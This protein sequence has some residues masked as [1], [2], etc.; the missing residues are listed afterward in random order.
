MQS[1]I[2][3]LIEVASGRRRGSL[4]LKNASIVNVFAGEILFDDIALLGDRIAGIGEYE[5]VEELDLK[6]AYVV[7][8]L[9]DGHMHLESAMTLPTEFAGAVLPRGTTAIIADPH[10]IANVCGVAG[11]RFML[12]NTAGT[13]PDV[14]FMLPSCIP[15][16]PFD[17]PGARLDAADL[18]GLK[19]AYRVL[20]LGELMDFKGAVQARKDIL[21]KLELFRDRIVDGHAPR[22]AGRE[23]NAYAAAGVATDHECDTVEEMLEKLR[24]GFYILI[25]EGS[26]ARNL[27]ELVKGVNPRNLRRCVFCTDDRHLRDI[28]RDGHIDNNIRLAVKHGLDPISAIT[29]ATLNAAECYGLKGRGAI[30]PGFIADMVVVDD[31]HT[32]EIISVFKNGRPISEIPDNSRN[33]R[34]VPEAV[35]NT[36]HTGALTRE[37]LEIKIYSDKANVIRVK[38]GSLLTEKVVKKVGTVD[39][40]FE[41]L[42]PGDPLKLAVVE[43]HKAS[44]R[45]GLALLDGFG[46]TGGAIASTIS[47]DSHNLIVAGD[48]DDDMLLA[49]EELSAKG[50]GITVTS[51]GRVLKT[52]PLPVAGLMSLK[53]YREID[54]ELGELLAIAHR[55]GVPDDI[56]PFMALSFLSLTVIPEIR[57]TDRGLFDVMEN[58][59]IDITL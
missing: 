55:L 54:G 9:I 15:A 50:G 39:G 27:A 48:N 58:R 53:P 26:A 31:L 7:P 4:V 34:T 21:A 59:L 25:R 51:G 2:K 10:E 43:R 13:G 12:E 19:D 44:G 28:V 46:L 52:L 16:T 40:R 23:L 57:I 38:P 20:G 33:W 49:M 36:M 47:H 14:F 6:G 8:G 1:G 56:E 42:H 22:L 24:L 3:E 30:A 5:G 45:T 41:R 29:M 11:I 37:R 18:R 17:S 32:F 35:M